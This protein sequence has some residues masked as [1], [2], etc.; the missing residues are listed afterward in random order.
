MFWNLAV[1]WAL[2]LLTKEH[3]G[4]LLTRLC[5]WTRRVTCQALDRCT[6]LNWVVLPMRRGLEC[7]E[8]DCTVSATRI[9]QVSR[10][11]SSALKLTTFLSVW[12]VI[13]YYLMASCCLSWFSLHFIVALFSVCV[14]IQSWLPLCVCGIFSR[15]I[16]LNL[17][18]FL[19]SGKD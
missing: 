8:D 11:S 7:V 6:F 5:V 14:L 10:S 19:L 15:V 18:F 13:Q 3:L 2:C 12:Q 1:F 4:H 9:F 17:R 16:S